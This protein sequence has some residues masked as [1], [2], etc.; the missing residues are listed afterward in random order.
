M[1][2][3]ILSIPPAPDGIHIAYGPDPNQFGELRLPTGSGPYPVVVV[4]HGGFWRAAYDLKHIG[5]LCVALTR[6]GAATWSLEYRRIGQDGGGW[7]GT[8]TDAGLGIDSLRQMAGQ[9]HL[10]LS[11]VVVIGHS[12]GGHLA[13]WAG[14]RSRLPAGDPLYVANPLPLHGVV[15]LAGVADLRQGYDLGLSARVVRDLLGGSPTQVPARYASGSP[16]ALLPLGLPQRLIHG[17]EDDIV[18]IEI[19]RSYAAAAR[20]KGDDA[21]LLDLPKTGH[22]EL[23]DPRSGA[24]PTVRDTTLGLLK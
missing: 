23:I 15:S 10:D 19:A 8:F 24:W 5:W 3:D 17:T 6:A 2:G 20:A 18:P 16:A 22:F 12:A 11:R 7:P 4:L 9:Y 21:Q 1:T 13:L 14:G